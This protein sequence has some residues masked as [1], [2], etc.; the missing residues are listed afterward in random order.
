MLQKRGDGCKV[1]F[2]EFNICMFCLL[3]ISYQRYDFP[4][5]ATCR[6]NA[7][8][9]FRV[10]KDGKTTKSKT[11]RDGSLEFDTMKRAEYKLVK[12]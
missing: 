12:R 5:W 8:G 6:I 1:I 9:R 3:V 4:T 11:Y 2:N 10:T 7:G